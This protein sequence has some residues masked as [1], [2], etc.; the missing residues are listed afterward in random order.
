[1]EIV[2]YKSCGHAFFLQNVVTVRSS[3]I[4][5]EMFFISLSFAHRHIL[6][7]IYSADNKVQ[8]SRHKL[9]V[10]AKEQAR[11]TELISLPV[12]ASENNGRQNIDKRHV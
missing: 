12:P 4:H 6:N 8:N 2:P 10:L 7:E 3:L 9:N 5:R 1:M 11:L